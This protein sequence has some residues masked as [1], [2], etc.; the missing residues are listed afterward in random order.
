VSARQVDD[1]ARGIVAASEAHPG[2]QPTRAG[3]REPLRKLGA[4]FR[5]FVDEALASKTGPAFRILFGDPDRWLL[6]TLTIVSDPMLD[7]APR[8]HAVDASIPLEPLDMAGRDDF[9]AWALDLFDALEVFHGYVTTSDMQGHRQQLIAE[10]FERGEI[11]P[12]DWDDPLYTTFDRVVSDVYWVNYFG[13]GFVDRWGSERFA[14]VGRR[15][16]ARPTGAVAA[17]A[18]DAPPAVDRSM[19]GLTEY[20]WKAPFYSAFGLDAFT[21]ETLDVPNPGH[22]VPTLHDHRNR[23]APAR[24]LDDG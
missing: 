2:F 12:P 4:G 3:T 1:L 9:V 16:E 22:H 15:V 23:S 17:W 7:R 8:T 21:H 13:P 10:A 20:P 5:A 14:A 19:R 11:A 6:G 24:P 18:T